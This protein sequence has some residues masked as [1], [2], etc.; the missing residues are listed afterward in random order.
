METIAAE[1]RRREAFGR[2]AEWAWLDRLRSDGVEAVR[3][4][5]RRCVADLAGDG[6]P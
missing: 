6:A 2:L 4:A 5:M 1:G 3:A